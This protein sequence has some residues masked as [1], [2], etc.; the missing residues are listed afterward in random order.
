MKLRWLPAV[1]GMPLLCLAAAG[2]PCAVGQ[3]V[4]IDPATGEFSTPSAAGVPMPEALRRPDPALSTSSVGLQEVVH[5]DGS[6]SVDLQ[7]RFQSRIY[8]TLEP[9][10]DVTIDHRTPADAQPQP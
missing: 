2:A 10:G 3:M 8:G 9:D 1:T 7:G 6:V 5:P 4:Y